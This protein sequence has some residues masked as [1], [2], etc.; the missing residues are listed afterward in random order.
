M[1]FLYEKSV[2]V[3]YSFFLLLLLLC[4]NLFIVIW[5]LFLVVLEKRKG[6][7]ES[8]PISIWTF[9]CAAIKMKYQLLKWNLKLHFWRSST[10]Y[11]HSEISNLFRSSFHIVNKSCY[12]LTW[13][14]VILIFKWHMDTTRKSINLVHIKVLTTSA[15]NCKLPGCGLQCCSYSEYCSGL[16]LAGLDLVMFCWAQGWGQWPVLP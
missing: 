16:W 7:S 1:N 14:L 13:V 6:I 5:Y 12:Y 10:C 8:C 11:K 2:P 15:S 9:C 3:L 4:K